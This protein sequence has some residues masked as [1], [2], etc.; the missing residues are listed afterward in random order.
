MSGDMYHEFS[1]PRCRAHYKVVRVK[2]E[3]GATHPMLECRVC[4]HE[5][6]PTEGDDILKYFLVGRSGPQRPRL[7]N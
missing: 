5:L 1:C 7:A 6:A 3:A 4:Q 2:S